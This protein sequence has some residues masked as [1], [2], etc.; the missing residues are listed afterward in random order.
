MIR[1]LWVCNAREHTAQ[2]L[3]FGRE[4]A[5]VCEVTDEEKNDHQERG[6]FPWKHPCVFVNVFCCY[7]KIARVGSNALGGAVHQD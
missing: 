2:T 5:A 7:G 4:Q 6:A 1:D 3:G